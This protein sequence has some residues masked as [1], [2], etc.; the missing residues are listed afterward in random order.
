MIT[1]EPIQLLWQVIYSAWTI[2]S[3]VI[4][5]MLIVVSALKYYVYQFACFAFQWRDKLFYTIYI[6]MT[7]NFITGI[8]I[9]GSSRDGLLAK[10]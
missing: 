8:E 3:L 10:L 1:N 6:F 7:A 5:F 2:K 9:N 4:P